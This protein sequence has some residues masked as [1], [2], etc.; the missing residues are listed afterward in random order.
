M[1]GAHLSRT[2]DTNVGMT[3]V[4]RG[5]AADDRPGCPAEPTRIVSRTPST[6]A[7]RLEAWDIHAADAEA[8]DENERTRLIADI[9]RLLREPAMP[10]T[11]RC[12][13]LTLIGWLARRR[14][15]EAPHA[16]GLAEALESDRRMQAGRAKAR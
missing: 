8:A 16:I 12:A 13:G 1:I 6:L 2:D 11:T 3:V 5:G 4:T 9:V 15:E 14:P 7:Q 10:E